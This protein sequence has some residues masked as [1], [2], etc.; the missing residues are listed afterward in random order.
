[1]RV[2]ES[3]NWQASLSAA[4]GSFVAA[5]SAPVSFSI[6]MTAAHDSLTFIEL[7]LAIVGLALLARIANR[8]GFSAIPL[9]L[10]GGLAFGNG[11]IAPLRLSENFIR[12]GAEIGVLLLLFMLGLEY[13]GKELKENL[14]SGL[15]DGL[16]DFL[17]NFTP[18]VVAGLLL[19]WKPMP[20]I[21]L[22]GVTYIS[23]SGVIARV[24][25][26][27][28]RMNHADTPLVLS[29]LVLEDLAMA[30]YLPVVS[31]L[32]A[33]GGATRIATSVLIAVA[34]VIIVLLIAVRYGGRLSRLASHQSDEIVLLTTLGVVLLVAG[35]A[36]RFQVSAAIAAFLVG[37]ALSGPIAEQSRR[38]VAPLRD[39]FAATFFFFFGLEV[40]PAT[41]PSALPVAALLAAVTGA[42]K[43]LTGVI[44]ARRKHLGLKAG[45]CA[46]VLLIPRGEFSIVIAGL[47]SAVEPELAPLSAAYVLLLAVAGPLLARLAR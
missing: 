34:A 5:N 35:T 13:T 8:F 45:V 42:T 18:G 16:I 17:A 43:L 15:P 4:P 33:G 7:G 19:G 28:G 21:L 36:E 26:E 23:S 47:G 2:A 9:Y 44:S 41:L 27:L 6:S 20:A 14:R 39:L 3:G 29:V 10:I 12:I 37:I 30:V 31:V 32:L 11:G 22:G 38:L 24:L 46:G 25:A 40:D 1:M